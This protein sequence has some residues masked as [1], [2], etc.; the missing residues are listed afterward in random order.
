VFFEKDN[1]DIEECATNKNYYVF[2]D[3][4]FAQ[5]CCTMIVLGMNHPAMKR[6]RAVVQDGRTILSSVV[7]SQVDFHKKYGGVVP[8]IAS[9][10]HI[11][12]IGPVISRGYG[13]GKSDA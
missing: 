2:F 7:A 4:L 3:V 1:C 5:E 13:T 6:Q 11:E 9:R 12:A 10:K 8:E